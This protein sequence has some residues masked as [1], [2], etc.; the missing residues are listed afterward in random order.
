VVDRASGIWVDSGSLVTCH[1]SYAF[2]AAGAHR[3][4]VEVT[5]VAPRDYSLANNRAEIDVNAAPAFTFS[6]SVVDSTYNGEDV[7][8]VVDAS[9]AI[10]Y[11]RDDTWRGANQSASVTGSWPSAIAFP[12]AAVSASAAS[13][14]ATWPLITLSGVEADPSDGT[15]ATCASRSD[16]SGYNW[17]GICTTNDGASPATQISVSAFAG[18]VTYH[19]LGVCQTTSA[20]Y[21]CAGGYT[22][23]SGS[24]ARPTNRHAIVDQVTFALNVTD[25]TGKVLQ[26]S[27]TM[28]VEPFTSADET[29]RTCDPQPDGTW[30]CFSHAYRETGVSGSGGQ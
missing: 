29:Q 20:F 30:H 4:A 24:D 16:D 18:E 3:V 10:M 26:A 27:P 12:L 6:G 21:D 15:G 5:N 14:G 11:H 19:S 23:N 7:E 9:G 2:A 22:W 8:D 25:A 13:G 17:L 28:P 1:F